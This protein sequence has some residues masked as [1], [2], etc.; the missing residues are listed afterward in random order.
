MGR[1]EMYHHP[2]LTLVHGVCEDSTSSPSCT[3]GAGGRV[4]PRAYLNAVKK[5]KKLFPLPG[6]EPQTYQP[7]A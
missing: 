4:G 3:H 1:T 2:F 6:F 5:K 7:I